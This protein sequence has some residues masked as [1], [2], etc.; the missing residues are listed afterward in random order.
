[1]WLSLYSQTPLFGHPLNTNTSFLRTVCFVCGEESSCV[2]VVVSFRKHIARRFLK[3]C[4]LR[5]DPMRK[6]EYE[7]LYVMLHGCLHPP[8]L[9]VVLRLARQLSI[10]VKI[11]KT[12]RIE[13]EISLM[14]QWK[15]CLAFSCVTI[16][17]LVIGWSHNEIS[18][19]FKPQKTRPFLKFEDFNA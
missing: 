5:A 16:S 14:R 12:E 6:G 8:F 13:K 15:P 17:R 4:S 2:S 7:R 10:Q 11:S 19:N 18:A 3:S 9:R 1:M